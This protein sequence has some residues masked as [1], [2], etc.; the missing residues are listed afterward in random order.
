MYFFL[1]FGIIN[2]LTAFKKN[3]EFFEHYQFL[4][5]KDGIIRGKR[6]ITKNMYYKWDFPIKYMVSAPVNVTAIDVA[7]KQLMDQTCLTFVRVPY[8]T[9]S[10]LNYK[11]GSG[12]VSFV[13]R[14]SDSR[15]QDISL[16]ENCENPT[17]IQHET[18]H[19]LGVRHEMSRPDRDEYI[20]VLSQNI[21]P[22]VMNNFKSD[23]VDKAETYG[24][25]Y[26]FGSIMHYSKTAGSMN[27]G[28]AVKAKIDHYINTPGQQ[29][30]I[31]FNDVKL[32]NYYYCN[33]TCK[34][35]STNCY[36]GGYP[37]PHNCNKCKCPRFFEGNDCS[38]VIPS[39]NSCGNTFFYVK[40]GQKEKI[41]LNGIKTCTIE[42]LASGGKKIKMTL[43]NSNLSGYFDCEPDSGLEIKYLQD[44]TV[45]GPI[46]CGPGSNGTIISE[47]NFVVLRYIGLKDYNNMILEY[48]LI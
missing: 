43:K 35:V 32:L 37:D 23:P 9:E 4:K 31:G 24:F 5:T 16:S 21:F 3:D 13:G 46:F 17:S 27:D 11:R 38:K 28:L 29:V 40:K 42:L 2:F 47:D 10:G 8:L 7:I 33:Y 6:A 26:D 45:S 14:I 25:K 1:I 34:G 12:C 39:D 20:E 15:P 30:E 18:M 22:F 36:Y 19:A 41:V 44:K 48:E